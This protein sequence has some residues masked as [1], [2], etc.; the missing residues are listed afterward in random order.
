MAKKPGAT[1]KKTAKQSSVVT[2]IQSQGRTLA[3][4]TYSQLRED[5]LGGK[6]PPNSKLKLEGLLEAYDVGMSPL[7]EALSRLVGDM[8]VVTEGQRGFWVAPLSLADLDDVTRIRGL[9]ET[10]ALALSIQNGDKEWE[11]AVTESYE[12]LSAVENS[13]PESP[14][15]IS[16]NLSRQ[17]EQC[18]RDF[19]S[20]L[21][22]AC[23]SPWLIRLRN[24]LYQQSERYRRVSLRE[25]R[26]H[27]D[28]QDEHRGI[29]NAVIKRN[30][31]KACDMIEH[32]LQQTADEVR[33]AI[34]EK[35]DLENA[36]QSPAPPRKRAR[37][38]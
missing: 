3:N 28:I 16:P 6:Y 33:R 4:E 23:N 24:L 5:I 22:S 18:N 15:D 14:E 38:R 7:R 1:K 10:Q 27:R 35:S 12:K 36:V 13:L 30:T 8:L 26:G 11:N 31:L 37:Q 34:I 29:Y 25:S 20:V 2:P 17:W 21:V 19:H 9:L 32:H